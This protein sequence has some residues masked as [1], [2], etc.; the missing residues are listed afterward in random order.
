MFNMLNIDW[1]ELIKMI[2]VIKIN[3]FFR[4]CLLKKLIYSFFIISFDLK[5]SYII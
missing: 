3:I 1:I 2:F 4:E 5:Q